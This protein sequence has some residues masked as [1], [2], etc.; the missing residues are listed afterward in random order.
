[1]V[2]FE[3]SMPSIRS[4]DLILGLPH[5]RR[6]HLADEIL[7]LLGDRR[8][9][10][11]RSAG[12]LDPVLAELP[13]SPSDHRRR[14]HD[15]EHLAPAGPEPGERGPE[16][17]FAEAESRPGDEALVHGQLMAEG[18]DLDLEV[19]GRTEGRGQEPEQEGQEVEHGGGP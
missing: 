13:A 9:T 10:W 8:A 15:D 3:I 18:E 14:P 11:T 1:M 12:E 19:E 17:A 4:S 2:D 7:D 6:R 5:V 16:E